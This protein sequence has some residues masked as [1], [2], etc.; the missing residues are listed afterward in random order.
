M[1]IVDEVTRRN[2]DTSHLLEEDFRAMGWHN[3]LQSARLWIAMNA[4]CALT[5]LEHGHKNPAA[6]SA[7]AQFTL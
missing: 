7:L 4:E 5:E 6:R 2:A 1:L 3:P